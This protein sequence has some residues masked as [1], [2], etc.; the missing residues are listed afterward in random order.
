MHAEIGDK[1][2][3][4]SLYF[5]YKGAV[6]DTYYIEIFTPNFEQLKFHYTSASQK[7]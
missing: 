7:G 1:I 4:A 2:M 6:D 5:N 3:A